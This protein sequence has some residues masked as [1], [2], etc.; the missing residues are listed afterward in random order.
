MPD[1]WEKNLFNKCNIQGNKA[2]YFQYTRRFCTS[3]RF[4]VK[5][6][7]EEAPPAC[8][9]CSCLVVEYSKELWVQRFQSRLQIQKKP[10]CTRRTCHPL[11]RVSA[12]RVDHSGHNTAGQ[13]C[14]SRAIPVRRAKRHDKSTGLE[15]HVPLPLTSYDTWLGDTC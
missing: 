6:H 14:R 11:G 5:E 13:F 10:A 4:Q 1:I 15:R 7:E 2:F 9:T 8:R 3:P 12:S